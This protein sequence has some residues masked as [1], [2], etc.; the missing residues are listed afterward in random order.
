[1]PDKKTK[2]LLPAAGI[3]LVLAGGVTAYLYFKGGVSG[4]ISDALNSAKLVPDEASMAVYISTEDKVWQKLRQLGTPQAQQTV[5]QSLENWKKD[6]VGDNNISWIGGVMV[7]VIPPDSTQGSIQS[8]VGGNGNIENIAQNTS[9]NQPLTQPKANFLMVVGIKD[10]IAAA[11]F[12]NKI[13]SQKGVK[14]KEID[15]Q[16]IK[17]TEAI[18]AQSSATYSTVLND[19]IVLAPQKQTVEKAIDTFKGEPSFTSKPGATELF[20]QNLNLENTLAQVYLPKG[21]LEKLSATS[22]RIQNLPTPLSVQLQQTQ[23]LVAGLSVED[24]GIRV[25]SISNLDP[26]IQRVS[27]SNSNGEISEK[28][29]SNTIV[30]LNGNNIN[31]WWSIFQQQYREYNPDFNQSIQQLRLQTKNRLNLDLDKDIFGWMDREFAFAAIPT[32]QGFLGQIGAGGVLIV[33]TSDRATATTAFQKLDKIVQQELPRRNVPIT[34]ETVKIGDKDVTQWQILG[35]PALVSHGWLDNNTA[36]IALG[37]SVT[38]TIAQPLQESLRDNQKFQTI[39][40]SLPASKNIYMYVDV[41]GSYKV[42]NALTPF[43]SVISP[44]SRL[45]SPKYQTV[46]NSIGDIGLTT[47]SPNKNTSQLEVFVKL[48]KNQNN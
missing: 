37:N 47:N 35:Q 17:I 5:A 41:D 40:Q 3:A 28:L 29:P 2:F 4:G 48:K 22:T 43:L 33:K 38:K 32:E 19:R 46:I 6:L 42:I 26:Q 39:S 9:Q 45:L 18:D 14:S 7:A 27:A 36:F 21:S 44:Q 34:V 30:L 16:G 15:Y 10:K 31:N 11:D 24:D 1:M 13:R 12:A 20:N 8:N 23:S 25:K